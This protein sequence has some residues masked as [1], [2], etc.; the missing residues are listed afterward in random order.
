MCSFFSALAKASFFIRPHGMP[1]DHLRWV[2]SGSWA[3]HMRMPSQFK[4]V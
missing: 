2:C 1:N 3:F 4:Y